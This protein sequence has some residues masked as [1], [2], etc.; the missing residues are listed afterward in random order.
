MKQVALLR[1]INVGGHNK[2]KMAD[3]RRALTSFGYTDV[4]TYI[5]SGNVVLTSP[6]PEALEG[7]L[8]GLI[9]GE[10]G[11]QVSVIVRAHHE[12]VSAVERYP[13][14]GSDPKLRHV[15][16][17]SSAPDPAR[18]AELDPDR[19]GEDR[20]LVDGA[21]LFAFVPGGM[22]RTRLTTAFFERLKVR[23]TVRNWRTLNKLVEMSAP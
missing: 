9:E 20:W 23:V 18:I 10:F 2:L 11:L 14:E 1:G 5:Q 4:A 17:L 22:A 21:E 8:R 3:L 15:G 12:L 13:F 6:R 19:G 7:E 16:F